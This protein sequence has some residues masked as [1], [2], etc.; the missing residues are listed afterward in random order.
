MEQSVSEWCSMKKTWLAT[1]A[2][3]DG[4]RPQAK[5]HGQPLEAGEVKETDS[6][7]APPQ[8]HSPADTSTLAQWNPYQTYEL[9]NVT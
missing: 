4:K 1:A 5:K 9:Q 6:S 3:G 7:L 8:D 2:F